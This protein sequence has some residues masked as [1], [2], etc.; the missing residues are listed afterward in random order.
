[1]KPNQPIPDDEFT[2]RVAQR[3]EFAELEPPADMW[4]RIEAAL[5][6]PPVVEGEVS[7]FAAVP[8]AAPAPASQEP[9][10][11]R[12][13]PWVYSAAGALLVLAVFG[14]VA[15]DTLFKNGQQKE[16]VSTGIYAEKAPADVTEENTVSRKSTSGTTEQPATLGANSQAE[17][18]GHL[19]LLAQAVH[20]EKNQATPVLLAARTDNSVPTVTTLVNESEVAG[21]NASGGNRPPHT[22]GGNSPETFAEEPARNQAPVGTATA[23]AQTQKNLLAQRLQPVATPEEAAPQPMPPPAGGPRE[24]RGRQERGYVYPKGQT[25]EVDQAIRN[26]QPG[27]DKVVLAASFTP[28]APFQRY[29][30]SGGP[31]VTS[32]QIPGFTTMAVGDALTQDY[33]SLTRTQ[34][35][36][37]SFM[38]GLAAQVPLPKNFFIS[39]GLDFQRMSTSTQQQAGL[40]YSSNASRSVTVLETHLE[41]PEAMLLAADVQNVNLTTNMNYLAIPVRAGWRIGS[42]KVQWV[43]SAGLGTNFF[44]GG[45]IQSSGPMGSESLPGGSR[46]PIQPVFLDGQ[47]STGVQYRFHKMSSLVAEPSVRYA[48]TNTLRAQGLSAHPVSVGMALRFLFHVQ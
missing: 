48:L 20:A 40:V 23:P 21:N 46:S 17:G 34:Q 41:R 38:A 14:L 22:N 36:R 43:I 33:Q 35:P 7:I 6:P 4:A 39:S 3:L 19:N 47:V 28:E 2:R 16:G 25:P 5:P 31:L 15:Y 26:K 13:L 1:M 42:P 30:V 24:R 8:P 45:N 44:V 12:I 37:F 9:K 32:G 18:T 11:F 27:K 29:E 10:R